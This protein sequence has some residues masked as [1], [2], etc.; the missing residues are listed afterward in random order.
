MDN[1]KP[2]FP[3]LNV[4]YYWLFHFILSVQCQSTTNRQIKHGIYFAEMPCISA[5]LGADT[6]YVVSTSATA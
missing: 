4:P 5:P 2:L 1:E 6:D 3:H